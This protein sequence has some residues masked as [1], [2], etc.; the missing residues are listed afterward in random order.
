ML[1]ADGYMLCLRHNMLKQCSPPLVLLLIMRKKAKYA[2]SCAS[3]MGLS[4]LQI[5]IL[6]APPRSLEGAMRAGNES[7]ACAVPPPRC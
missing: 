6:V 5:E 7:R 2:I 3:I 4:L 1:V